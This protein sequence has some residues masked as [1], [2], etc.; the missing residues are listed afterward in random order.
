M[1]GDA[2]DE[3]DEQGDEI[4]RL[5]R[6]NESLREAL[7]RLADQDATLSVQ[8]GNV[9]VTM[10]ATLTDEEQRAIREAADAYRENDG[11]PDCE[12]I[13]ETLTKLLARLSPRNKTY[14]K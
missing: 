14:P 7:R 3:V 4:A 5:R 9:I 10:D 11:D 8:G 12:R 6:E 1:R 13:A 2:L